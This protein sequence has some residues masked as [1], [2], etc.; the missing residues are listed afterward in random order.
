MKNSN[1]EI[2]VTANQSNRTFTIRKL[3]NGKV[4]AKYRTY[5]MPTEEFEEEK[6]NTE[7]DWKDFLTTNNYFKIKN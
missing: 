1:I 5:P 2:K 7:N 6:M 3:E 4:Y